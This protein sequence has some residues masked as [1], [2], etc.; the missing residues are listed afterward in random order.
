MKKTAISLLLGMIILVPVSHSDPLSGSASAAQL[1]ELVRQAKVQLEEMRKQL[2]VM[3]N[4]KEM[5]QSGLIKELTATG[6]SMGQMFSD[7][8]A[9]ERQIEDWKDD[10]A[11]TRQI[12]NDLN[13]LERTYN[14]AEGGS[15]IDK[16]ATYSGMLSSLNRM[17][18]LG[19]AQ[20]K[21]EEQMLGGISTDDSQK[22]TADNTTSMNRLELEREMARQRREVIGTDIVIQTMQN[23]NYGNLGMMQ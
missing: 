14:S 11:G 20:A 22:I 2:S 5:Q 23:V 1:A 6:D 12:E 17:K 7:I 10:P 8:R 19:H 3:E 9:M 16:G 13:R 15:A 4:L 21:R 18:W